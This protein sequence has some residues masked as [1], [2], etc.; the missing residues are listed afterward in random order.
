MS[1]SYKRRQ[2]SSDFKHNALKLCKEP[3]YTTA[4]VAKNLGISE[5]LLYKWRSRYEQKGELAFP[6]NGREALTE[7]QKENREL[8]KRLR[9]AELERDILKK[10]LG[11]FS[12]IPK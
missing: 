7:E 4:Q 11:I 6:G 1:E 3:G 8:R 10:A 9:D 5:S 2:Y 12:R